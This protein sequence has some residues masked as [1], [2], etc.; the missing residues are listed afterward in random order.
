MERHPTN[1]IQTHTFSLT[2]THIHTHTHTHTRLCTHT[3]GLTHTLHKIPGV[4]N[5]DENR[6]F[7][8]QKI[9]QTLQK[10]L[11]YLNYNIINLEKVKLHQ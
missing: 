5:L 10:I 11:I 6:H 4:K 7:E 3:R 8:I 9:N 2:R 1:I